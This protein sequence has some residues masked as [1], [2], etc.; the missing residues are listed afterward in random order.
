MATILENTIRD[1]SYVLD[2]QFS[3][4]QS[5]IVVEGLDR[6][7]FK[8]IEVGHGLGLGA[9]KLQEA[10]LSAETDET[11]IA[12]ARAHAKSARIGV[13]FIPGIGTSGDIDMAADLGIDFIR[14]GVNIDRYKD[15][16]RI[17]EYAKSLGLWVSVN[18][19]KSYAVKRFEFAKVVREI[20]TWGSADAVYLVDSAGCMLP[21]E[22][23]SYIDSARE[24]AS[25]AL[26]FHGHNNLSLAVANSLA[27]ARAGAEYVD[28]SIL[29][30]GRSAGNAQ[31]EILTHL[32]R[33]ERLSADDFNQYDLY[34]FAQ[35]TIQ[36]LM[37]QTQGLNGRD[38]HIGVSK[39]HTSYSP[40]INRV[41]KEYDLDPLLLMKHVSDINCLDPKE[42]F[43]IQ[44]AQSLK[45]CDTL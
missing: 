22:V 10:G 37:P 12:G 18:L 31:T 44:I 36:P 17:A 35:R 43:V 30:M 33:Q 11:Y 39:F 34:H 27:A 13:F 8:F 26:G 23:A 15:L 19:M 20:S 6:L 40:L 28:S 16:E 38:I 42:D 4:E 32:L 7:G 21:E 14:L 29:G 25:V 2:F 24:T 5:N 45:G 1:G 3:A 41:A 9:G